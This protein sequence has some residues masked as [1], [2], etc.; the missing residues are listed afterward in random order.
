MRLVVSGKLPVQFA[1]RFFVGF[2]GFFF[3][4][5]TAEVVVLPVFAYL[6]NVWFRKMR[7]NRHS[8]KLK[9]LSLA[10]W[11]VGLVLRLS[12]VSKV[13]PTVIVSYAVNMINLVFR[14]FPRHIEKREPRSLVRFP[15]DFNFYSAFAGFVPGYP[16]SPNS[17][18][19]LKPCKQS[20]FWTVMHYFFEFFLSHVHSPVMT[21]IA[22]TEPKRKEVC[23]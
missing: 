20:S 8:F 7:L 1:G 5:K 3:S 9:L 14:P 4:V 19:V 16:V 6:S 17:G 12:G 10:G 2:M 22:Q 18:T 11:P 21:R 15:V 13:V 23:A